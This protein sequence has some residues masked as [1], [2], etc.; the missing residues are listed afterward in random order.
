MFR[1]LQSAKVQVTVSSKRVT[2]RKISQ[3]VPS[4][5]HTDGKQKP[6]VAQ[7]YRRFDLVPILFLAA[8]V[9]VGLMVYSAH[10]WTVHRPGPH[11]HMEPA[12]CPAICAEEAWNNAWH[13]DSFGLYHCSE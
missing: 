5:F 2:E 3:V 12:F 4:K 13:G 10:R 6:I 1:P 7:R 11:R 9:P 8:V